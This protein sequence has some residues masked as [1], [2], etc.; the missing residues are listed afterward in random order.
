MNNV[1]HEHLVTTIVDLKFVIP[2]TIDIMDFGI[3]ERERE[4]KRERK[5][6]R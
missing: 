1:S 2:V 5:R 6:R 3:R 4:R